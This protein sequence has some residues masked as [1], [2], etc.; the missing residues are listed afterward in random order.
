MRTI[1]VQYRTKP[2][3]ADENQQ[4]IEQVFAE[5]AER[6]PPNLRYVSMRLEDGVSFVHVAMETGDGGGALGD[7]PAFQAFV[8]D[9][10]DRCE[11]PPA[12]TG[13]AVVGS[14]GF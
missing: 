1:V 2:A 10:A 8:R 5:L 7:L 3:A 11:V 6:K 13:A 14:Y 9:I 12:A 4:L